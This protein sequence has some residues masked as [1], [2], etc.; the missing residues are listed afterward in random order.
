[1]LFKALVAVVWTF[2]TVPKL[3]TFEVGFELGE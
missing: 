1:M 2:S 3:M